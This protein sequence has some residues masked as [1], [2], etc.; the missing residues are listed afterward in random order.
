MSKVY[1]KKI[2]SISDTNNINKASEELLDKLVC[3]NNIVLNE[4]IPLKVHFGEKGNTT[5]IGSDK[6][7]GIYNF[8]NKKTIESSYIETNVLYKG[9]RMTSEKHMKLAKEHG[10]TEYPII[11]ADGEHGEKYEEV[12]INQKNYNKCKIGKEIL[13]YNQ[14]IVVSHFKGHILAGFGGAVKQLAMG[15]ASRGGKLAQHDNSKLV[16][17]PLKCKACHICEKECP[18]DAI[19]VIKKAKIDKDKCIGCA[20]CM[21]V[22]PY[23]AIFNT[24]LGVKDGN[25]YERLAEYALAASLNKNNIYITFALNITKLCDCEGHAM[26]PI[27]NDIGVFASLDPIAIDKACIDMANSSHGSQ[28][29]HKG[30]HTLEYGSKIGLGSLE[31]E[32]IEL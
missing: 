16:I 1:F 12:E 10:F 7:K 14:M 24:W 9:E 31:Y 4:F 25:F 29:F 3:D 30:L 20:S 27:T 22:C 19:S 5:F 23:G 26:K 15:C 21:A 11:I 32:L 6:F 2:K 28:I 13:R 17:N 18:V 8:L